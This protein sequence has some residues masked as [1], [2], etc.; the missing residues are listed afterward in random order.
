MKNPPE[1]D[2]F[3]LFIFVFFATFFAGGWFFFLILKTRGWFPFE[4]DAYPNF[5]KFLWDF[6]GFLSSGGSIFELKTPA[7]IRI[8]I[9]L[10]FSLV[11]ASA[12][13][14]AEY[15]RGRQNLEG[16]HMAGRRYLKGRDA[17]KAFARAARFECRRS[18]CGIQIH[19]NLPPIS[20]TREVQNWLVWGSVG[21]GKTN[22]IKSLLT[23]VMSRGDRVFLF[24][25]KGDFTEF[26]ED[27]I[28]LIAPWDRRSAV[29]DIAADVV[30]LPSARAL[31]A[32][33][34]P[35]PK[36]ASASPIWINGARQI[37][38]GAILQLIETKGRDW[39]FEDLRTLCFAP[40]EELLETMRKHFAEGLGAVDGAETTTKGILAT[41]TAA[42]SLLTDLAR[43]WP[44]APA[45]CEGFS[46]RRWL[47]E[48]DDNDVA[49]RDKIVV[50]QSNSRFESLGSGLAR[51]LMNIAS[52]TVGDPA[53]LGESSTRRVW[54]LTDEI[55]QLG[56]LEGLGRLLETGRSKGIRVVLGAQDVA[57]IRFVYGHDRA[58]A[59]ISQIGNQIICRLNAGESANWV[60]KDLIGDR[61]LQKANWTCAADGTQS[62]SFSLADSPVTRPHQLTK[63]L[64]PRRNGTYILWLAYDDVLRLRI[65]FVPRVKRREPVVLASWAD[66]DYVP[67]PV[68]QASIA[69]APEPEPE[70]E[71]EEIPVVDQIASHVAE[72]A[73]P[74]TELITH[75][76]EALDA[77]KP[78]RPRKRLRKKPST[79]KA[80]P[81]PT[82]Q[83]KQEL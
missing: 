52:E 67:P 3:Y 9:P 36:N 37:L 82:P 32:S 28:I 80:K 22:F 20:L 7:S 56:V 8:V 63:D 39:G 12:A 66:P 11:A 68:P 19:A 74:G 46:M 17:S 14:S 81:T 76:L 62:V 29:W 71:A 70:A 75:M 65:P 51:V 21:S 79:S 69:P 26:I 64:G 77:A 38:I 44:E 35:E 60:A 50:V 10:L 43:A 24:D 73:A 30:D 34:L 83:P 2:A 23:Q 13:A 42:L 61:Q 33:L 27:N 1:T 55:I 57:Q 4:G 31:A 53:Q 16:V 59:W 5:G 41:M 15:R 78:S 72:A 47:K 25:V 49:A 40:L 18:G 58:A 45:T 48:A 54:F 6:R